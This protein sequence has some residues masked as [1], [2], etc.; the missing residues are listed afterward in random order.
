MSEVSWYLFNKARQ[1]IWAGD[2]DRGKQFL[3]EVA[4]AFQ[5]ARYE[6]TAEGMYSEPYVDPELRKRWDASISK[7][8]TRLREQHEKYLTG[9]EPL[10]HVS[11]TLHACYY[12]LTVIE[13]IL[14]AQKIAQEERKRVVPSKDVGIF[15]AAY[16]ADGP[17]MLIRGYA[18]EHEFASAGLVLERLGHQHLH[19]EYGVWRRISFSVSDAR[20]LLSCLVHNPNMSYIG[21][22]HIFFAPWFLITGAV[23]YGSLDDED[24]L[25][26]AAQDFLDFL[27][28]LLIR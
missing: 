4:R 2:L 15:L 22:A 9:I 6:G 3:R 19:G 13:N 26:S 24:G 10:D 20:D 1:A 7:A 14:E 17:R 27:S 25:Y 5:H 18:P 23:I 12:L 11:A 21:S 28:N 16:P 8:M